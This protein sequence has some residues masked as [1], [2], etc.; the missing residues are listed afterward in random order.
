[1]IWIVSAASVVWVLGWLS[2][3]PHIEK[4]PKALVATFFIWPY[5][6]GAMMR[7]GDR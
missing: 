6:V 4:T 3:L 7:S 1:M 5:V 2:L